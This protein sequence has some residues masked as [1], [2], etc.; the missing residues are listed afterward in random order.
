MARRRNTLMTH[1][2]HAA[3]LTSDGAISLSAKRGATI[4]TPRCLRR[5]HNSSPWGGVRIGRV[6]RPE[7]RQFT[8]A[9]RDGRPF[10]FRRRFLLFRRFTEYTG[11]TCDCA[12]PVG[13]CAR[14]A[15]LVALLIFPSYNE[16]TRA[17]KQKWG[18]QVIVTTRTPSHNEDGR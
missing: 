7:A 8:R 11:K 12:R 13:D 14:R 16:L 2:L 18:V 3:Y 6:T 15:F 10:Y 17:E 9:L 5:P 1:M 4:R